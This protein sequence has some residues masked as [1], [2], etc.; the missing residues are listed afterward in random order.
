M[1]NGKIKKVV[2]QWYDVDDKGN[3]KLQYRKYNNIDKA[4]AF[5]DN[6]LKER[7][8]KECI[9]KEYIQLNTDENEPMP[10]QLVMDI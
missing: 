3:V 5:V 2:I 6:Q 1:K 9:K 10:E 8:V 4:D 7:G